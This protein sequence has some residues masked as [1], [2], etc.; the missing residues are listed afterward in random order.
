MPATIEAVF[1]MLDVIIDAWARGTSH[2]AAVV[3]STAPIAHT[4]SKVARAHTK[5]IVGTRPF[6]CRI[7]AP[8]TE[9]MLAYYSRQRLG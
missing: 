6:T 7:N 3:S 5:T 8:T 2:I 4:P 9:G 1:L